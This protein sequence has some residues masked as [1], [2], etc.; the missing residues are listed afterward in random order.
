MQHN[1]HKKG[2]NAAAM[3]LFEQVGAAEACALEGL[4]VLPL[5][6]ASLMS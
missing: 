6:D 2:D 5:V 1:E 3:V 4:L